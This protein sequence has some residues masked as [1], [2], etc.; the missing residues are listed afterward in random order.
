[1]AL[2]VIPNIEFFA[3][4]EQVPAA[5][6]G[7]GV[8]PDIPTWSVRDYGNR[9]GIFRMMKV[10]DKFGIRGTVALNSDSLQAASRDPRRSCK[11]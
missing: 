10:F 6:G 4:D 9:I 3:L 11:A 7:G 5:A 2:W 1:M 8:T